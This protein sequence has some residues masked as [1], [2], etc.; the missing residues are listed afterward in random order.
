MFVGQPQM[1]FS[2]QGFTP[3]MGGGAMMS[4]MSVSNGG[5]MSMQQQGE[6]LA[7]QGP[8]QG[9]WGMNQVSLTDIQRH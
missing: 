6:V 5:Y 9:Q 1:Q 3:G 7:N 2:P 8:Q 4:G